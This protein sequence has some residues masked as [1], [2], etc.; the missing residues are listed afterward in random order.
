M[1]H[2]AMKHE[3]KS[4]NSAIRPGPK[5]QRE[6]VDILIRFRKAPVALTADISEMFLQV[7]LREQDRQYHRFLWRNCDSTQA[8]KVYEFQRLLFGNAASPFCAQYTLHTHAQT[9]AQEYP[10]AAESVD[11]SMYVDDLL[12]SCETVPDAQSLQLQLSELLALAGFK[13]RKWASNDDEVLRDIP[14]EDRLSSFEIDSQETSSTKTLG[15]SWNAKTDV[16]TFQVKQPDPNE[17]PTK[18]NVLSTIASL[19]DPLQFLSPFVLRAKVLLQEI[20][21][22]GIGWDDV[23]PEEL[24][25]KWERWLSELPHLSKVEIP[26]CLRKANPEKIELHLFSDASNAAYATVAYLVCHYTDYPISSCLIASKCRVAPVKTMTIPRLELMGAILSVRLAQ[27]ILKVLTVDR[28]LFWTDSENVWHW[29][30]N[31]SREFKP[32]VANRIGE[33]QRSTNPDQWYHVPGAMNP[34]DLATRGLSAEQL[35]SCQFWTEGP[36]FLKDKTKGKT[37]HNQL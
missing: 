5:L 9:H 36:K 12:D 27:T 31:Q 15:V 20:W 29:V 13:L 18:R 37:L 2:A 7:G 14:K 24:R 35:S 17:A 28:V 34:A 16:F 11:N 6:I 23:L 3:G 26:R 8:P 32:F 10:A 25:K 4:L 30:R 33:I 22:A 21:T 19:Y 1:K